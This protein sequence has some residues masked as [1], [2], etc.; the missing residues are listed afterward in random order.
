VRLRGTP[1]RQ[2]HTIFSKL[3]VYA[4]RLLPCIRL[5][6]H[7]ITTGSTADLKNKKEKKKLATCSFS[8]FFS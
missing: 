8:P 3:L 1:A 2:A 7:Q 4:A 6:R 5:L